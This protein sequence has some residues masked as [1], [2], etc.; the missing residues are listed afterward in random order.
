[1]K[2]IAA[3]LLLGAS[4]VAAAESMAAP[5]RP[6]EETASG[7][8]AARAA[9]PRNG[10]SAAVAALLDSVDRELAAARP[11][12]ALSLLER[13][14][15]IEPQNPALWHYLALANLE[16]GNYAQ[17][18]AMAAK[19]Q[20]LSGGNRTLRTRNAGL[21]A[22]AQRALGKP[23]LATSRDLAS[24][25]S[26]ERGTEL[27]TRLEP[28]T[29]YVDRGNRN[30]TQSRTAQRV[31]RASAERALPQADRAPSAGRR[32]RDAAPRAESDSR[33]RAAQRGECWIWVP[34]HLARRQAPTMRCDALN[35][36][37]ERRASSSSVREAPAQRSER[38]SARRYGWSGFA[39]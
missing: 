2:S 29:T 39:L 34:N 7:S 14:L 8:A 37:T 26:R 25:A 32:T 3:A 20:N 21:M 22:S 15:R 12:Q 6:G 5:E 16:L 33:A 9:T 24:L 10:E 18:E 31:L 28:A 17:A 38:R 13:A 4:C 36:Q 35:G 11:A 23:V 27:D 1:M 19:S 30:E